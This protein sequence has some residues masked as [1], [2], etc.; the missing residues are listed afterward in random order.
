[1]TAR[2]ALD[3]SLCFLIV[4]AGCATA[5]KAYTAGMDRE[6]SGDYDGAAHEYATAL[7]RDPALPNVRGRLV[8]AGREAVR[9]H[10]VAAGDATPEE[11]ASAYDAA[12]GLVARAAR[13]GVEVER[14]AT[15]EADR[16]TVRDD[17]VAWLTEQAGARLSAGDHAGALDRLGRAGR[18]APSA[19]R[20]RAL[21]ALATDV[22]GDWARADLDAGRFRDGLAHVDAALGRA[23]GDPALLDVRDA[24]LDVGTVVAAVLPI[25]GASDTP[26]GFV[27]DLE[28]VLV[29]ERLDSPPAFVA[30]VDPAEVRRWD[31]RARGRRGDDLTPGDLT[32]AARELG[33]DLGVGVRVPGVAEEETASDSRQETAGRLDR[34]VRV[35]YT[36]RTHTL[37]LR[38]GA[39]LVA[40]DAR[41]GRMVCERTARAEARVTY[42]VAT[43]T[44]DARDLDLT[45]SQRAAFDPDAADLAYGRA[46]DL[47]R[48]RLADALAGEVTAC[49][50][51]RVG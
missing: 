11:A 7:E 19:D 31:R 32:S 30:L 27:R 5:T 12:A 4:V 29:E 48:D 40:A 1:M 14:P 21:D 44:A 45:R 51:G 41:T 37:T 13:I 36:V 24:I 6:V 22:Y 49:V 42:D 15:F 2:Y 18:F 20:Q 47:L 46:L 28:D 10:V 34:P 39:H 17:A 26:R 23:P 50:Q 16:R 8:V 3:L 35:P 9:R 38:A 33:A 43:A 25:E